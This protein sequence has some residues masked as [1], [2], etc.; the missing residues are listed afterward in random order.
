MGNGKCPWGDGNGQDGELVGGPDGRL[1]S[2]PSYQFA[3]APRTFPI[4]HSIN[5][6]V[7]V[8]EA[9]PKAHPQMT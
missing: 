4:T 3:I 9:A 8:N 2:S 1:I 7:Q 5:E 6:Q